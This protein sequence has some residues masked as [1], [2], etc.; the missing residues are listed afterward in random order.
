M[1]V[2]PAVCVLDAPQ[3]MEVSV[4][5]EEKVTTMKED[6]G[7]ELKIKQ[8]KIEEEIAL[9]QQ[10]IEVASKT[11]TIVD[12]AEDI[13]ST[14][15]TTTIL[16][17][18][19]PPKR[20]PKSPKIPQKQ[21]DIDGKSTEADV[22]PATTDAVVVPARRK[23]KTTPPPE[24]SIEK[25]N[26]ENVQEEVEDETKTEISLVEAPPAL[27][28]GSISPPKR[29]SKKSK[30]SPELSKEEVEETKFQ[31]SPVIETAASVSPPKRKSKSK[32]VEPQDSSVSPMDVSIESVDETKKVATIVLE[33]PDTVSQ[34]IF[35][36]TV[37]KPKQ[38][39][40]TEESQTTIKTISTTTVEFD[41]AE[42]E[43]VTTS[44]SST[45]QDDDLIVG[46][47][48]IE[49]PVPS[50]DQ[51]QAHSVIVEDL[52]KPFQVPVTE[53][54]EVVPQE[55]EV[56]PISQEISPDFDTTKVE[57][58]RSLQEKFDGLKKSACSLKLHK[59][60]LNQWKLKMNRKTPKMQ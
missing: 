54:Q 58:A 39:A 44:E 2:E 7:T 48:D 1:Q 53:T 9:S 28:S 3:R 42:S 27:E 18:A 25:P 15:V 38:E 36:E 23:S 14:E 10:S 17:E 37:I 49:K 29:K 13:P 52:S 59:K 31:T 24:I 16:T 19:V 50:E 26:K 12:K 21:M 32:K 57:D 51:E 6:V 47:E 34:T 60:F 35:V 43:K 33:M 8:M 56:Q 45:R 20:K 46:K 22:S 55:A 11:D 30:I 5:C 4:I 41:Q 40:P